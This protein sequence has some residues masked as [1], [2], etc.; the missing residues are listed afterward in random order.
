MFPARECDPN[1]STD[2]LREGDR[3][4]MSRKYSLLLLPIALTFFAGCD[5]KQA[6]SQEPSLDAAKT[7]APAIAE[8]KGPSAE[9]KK[10]ADEEA[11]RKAEEEKA[12]AELAANPLTECCRALGKQAFTL[13]SPEFHGASKACGEALTAEKDLASVLP[14]IKK[15]L[16]DKPL[17]EEC[18]K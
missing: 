5:D 18:A 4:I 11:A 16:K 2:H 7:E 8:N 13:R 9:E 14:E 12:Q 15:S 10:A 17:P 3:K 1:E 6:Q